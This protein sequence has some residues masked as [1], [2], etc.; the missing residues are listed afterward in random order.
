MGND[1]MASTRDQPKKELSTIISN[2][3]LA[4][5]ALSLLGAVSLRYPTY[6]VEHD[7]TQTV[8]PSH[9][10]IGGIASLIAATAITMITSYRREGNPTQK[11]NQESCNEQYG[12][13]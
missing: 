6:P 9:L 5:G 10:A 7:I 12:K 13:K 8:N 4:G 11:T 1:N 2:L 3:F